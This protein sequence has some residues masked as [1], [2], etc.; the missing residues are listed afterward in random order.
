YP[1][2]RN[3][4]ALPIDTITSSLEQVVSDGRMAS[5][6]FRLRNEDAL[7]NRAQE[8]PLLGWG[9]WG[10][11]MLY[12]EDGRNLVVTDGTWIIYFGKDGWLGYIA[13][14]G[15]LT[16]PVILLA[17]GKRARI[18]AASGALSVVLV[19]NLLDLV[20]NSGLTPITWLIAGAIAGRLE[21][22]HITIQQPAVQKDL[23]ERSS[24]YSRDFSHAEPQQN[25]R[26]SN[27]ALRKALIGQLRSR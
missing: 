1:M 6:D 5:L 8:R 23:L 14:F 3:S 7:L 15:L 21:L 25:S 27:T 2:A 12:D 24:R 22:D 17:F 11:N 9:G 16:L 13:T 4:G 19:T 20:I 10:R 26:F 18:D